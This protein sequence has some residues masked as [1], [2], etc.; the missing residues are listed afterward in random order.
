MVHD[1]PTARRLRTG[2]RCVHVAAH[3]HFT[4]PNTTAAI[5]SHRALEAAGFV[6]GVWQWVWAKR[7]WFGETALRRQ[8]LIG[9]FGGGEACGWGQ[10][11]LQHDKGRGRIGARFPFMPHKV[12]G[13]YG[14][15]CRL[16]WGCGRIATPPY[17]RRL[18]LC[19]G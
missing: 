2:G 12:G 4:V 17:A 8:R 14:G 10:P 16:R 5:C 19:G 11:L 3:T 9:L 15:H 13:R 7:R 6:S 18:L 1:I